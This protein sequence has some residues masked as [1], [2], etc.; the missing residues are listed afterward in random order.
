MS[1]L[2]LMNIIFLIFLCG[3]YFPHELYNY[4]I[5]ISNKGSVLDETKVTSSKAD[6][7]S[8]YIYKINPNSQNMP[9]YMCT[10]LT[11]SC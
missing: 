9:V 8:I 11:I 7:K 1:F 3:Q 5:N 4:F 6:Y 10:T 2:S